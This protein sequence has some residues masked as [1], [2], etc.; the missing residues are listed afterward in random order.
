MTKLSIIQR[1]LKGL[2]GKLVTI[3]LVNGKPLTGELLEFDKTALKLTGRTPEDPPSV[4]QFGQ[5]TTYHAGVPPNT[6]RKRQKKND[7]QK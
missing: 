6:R 5:F 2:L 1:E 3:Y 4:V 7:T